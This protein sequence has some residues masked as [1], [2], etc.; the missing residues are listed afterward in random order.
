LGNNTGVSW[1]QLESHGTYSNF[2]SDINYWGYT[3]VQGNTNAPNSTSSQWYRGRFSLGSGYGL[4]SAGN[5]YWLELSWPRYNS[6]TA[7]HMWSRTTEN[8]SIGSWSQVG[9][10]IIGTGN[11]TSDY[12]APVFYDNND[13]S[14][15]TD[16][17]ST[18]VYNVLN[19]N[20]INAKNSAGRIIMTGNLHIDAFGGNDI[21][22]N[23]YA[24]ART[25]AYVNASEKF[26]VDTD[27]I[28]YAFDQFRSPIV[29]DYNDTG[30][31]SD[32]NGTNRLNFVNSN[33]HY[34]QPGYMLYSDHG[35]WQGEYNKIQ[36]HGNHLYFQNNGGG[37][38][39]IF[40]RGDGGERAWIDYNGNFT[41]SGNVTAY[42]D[43]RLKENV[44]T[45]SNA[46][47]LV[48]RL[49]GV[50][51]DWIADKKHSYGLIAQEVEEV[52]PELVHESENGTAEGDIKT[53]IKSVDYSKIVSVLIEA[54]KEQQKQID[55]LKALI[56]K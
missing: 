14:Y 54:I 24:S 5:S 16:Q 29:Y 56:K 7:G 33:N 44:E 40:R 1:G 15:Y 36:W 53:I 55:E 50:T 10:N 25:R 18:S 17:N 26:R 38:L 28:V 23:Y 8:G 31:Y 45:I 19:V 6:T 27:G 2:N 32:P 39:A 3:Y 20:T 35:A 49:R 22:L 51:F 21:Y 43:R 42:S 34:I 9:A 12:R 52:I 11:A 13:T 47:S 46:I 30:Y 48:Q 4:N 41:A 37:Y